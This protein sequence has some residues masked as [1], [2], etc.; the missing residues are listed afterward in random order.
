MNGTTTAINQRAE[1]TTD[2]DGLGW[3]FE[4]RPEARVAIEERLAQFPEYAIWLQGLAS[5]VIGAVERDTYRNNP[6]S[7]PDK[8]VTFA[9]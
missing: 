7:N 8:R 5:G 3:L 2:C 1:K 6:G 4:G 9:P